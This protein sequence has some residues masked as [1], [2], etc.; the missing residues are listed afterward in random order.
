MVR[1]RKESRIIPVF[2]CKQLSK[3][4]ILFSVKV[5]TQDMDKERLGG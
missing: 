3:L 2:W 4:V 1:K 5:K